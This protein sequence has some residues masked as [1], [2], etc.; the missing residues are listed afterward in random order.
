MTY[1]RRVKE[2]GSVLV[3]AAVLSFGMFLLGLAYLAFVD[4]LIKDVDD[5]IIDSQGRYAAFAGMMDAET[6]TAMNSPGSNYSLRGVN[7]YENVT[8]RPLIYFGGYGQGDYLYNVDY[9]VAGVGTADSYS[10]RGRTYTVS[11]DINFETYADYLYLSD[12][13]RDSVRHVIIRFWTPDT[14]DGKVHSND[15]LHVMGSPRFIKRVTSSVNTIDPPNN[16]AHFDDGLYLNQAEINFPDQAEEIRRY[17]GY[18]GWGTSTLDSATEITFSGPYIYRRYCRTTIDPPDTIIN[19]SPEHIASAPR[20]T[21]PASGALFIDG[22]VYIKA[23]RFREDILDPSFLSQGFEGRLTVASSDTM[24]IMD[25]LV[26]AHSRPD[27]SVPD[28]ITDVLGLISENFIMVGKDVEDTVYINAA[29]AALNGSI[30][31]QDIYDFWGE[32]EKQSLFI[33]GSL[34]QRNRG[35]VHTTDYGTR[36]FIEKDYHYDNRL[37]KYPPPHF[38]PTGRRKYVYREE[39]FPG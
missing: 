8:Y 15:T 35:I 30:S 10:G 13:E 32:N 37:Q 39:F 11:R 14:L 17:T 18:H 2:K 28:S 23:D 33:Y 34:A 3:M 38:M 20:F 22:K 12:V 36:G 26:Y 16:N 6:Y 1:H 4:Q 19:C 5:S 25:N 27:N 21:F 7:F 31:V 24:I 9:T 29:L